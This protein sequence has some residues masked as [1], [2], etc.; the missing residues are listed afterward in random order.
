M[1]RGTTKKWYFDFWKRLPSGPPTA[2]DAYVL[3]GKTVRF[4]A[5]EFLGDAD[6]AAKIAKQSGGS[7][8]SFLGTAFGPFAVSAGVD[9]KLSIKVNGGASQVVTLAAGASRTT[10]QVADDINAQTTGF[11][12]TN[13]NNKLQFAGDSGT[14]TIELE[15]VANSFYAHGG[16]TVG[17]YASGSG[18]TF[19]THPVTGVIQRA[20][21]VIDPVD[22]VNIPFKGM[23]TFFEC[24]VNDAGVIHR[25]LTGSLIINPNVYNAI[26]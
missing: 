19:L 15:A 4:T 13:S 5:K 2:A 3:T 10:Q 20:L 7:P 9:D 17:V 24:Y 8:P 11:T 14:T 26:A 23:T 1:T 25:P 12:V 16:L 22:T 21:V 6:G 18:I